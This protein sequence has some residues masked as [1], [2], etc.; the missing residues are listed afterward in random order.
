MDDTIF[1]TVAGRRRLGQ[2]VAVQQYGQLHVVCVIV[3]F[4]CDP[5]SAL[6]PRPSAGGRAVAPRVSCSPSGAGARS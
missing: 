1:T 3:I 2:P 6:V 5:F 4:S